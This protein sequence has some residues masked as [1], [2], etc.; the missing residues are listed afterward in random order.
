MVINWLFVQFGF[1]DSLS[2]GLYLILISMLF[3]N[4]PKRGL[5]LSLM[6]TSSRYALNI[7]LV[8]KM[9]P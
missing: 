4:Q 1:L 6:K 9:T 5:D 7:Q 2:S 3:E 8:V